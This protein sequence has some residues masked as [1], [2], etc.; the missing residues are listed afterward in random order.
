MIALIDEEQMSGEQESV[1]SSFHLPVLLHQTVSLLQPGPGKLFLDGT[2][3]GGGHALALL[4]AGASVIGCDQD[5]EALTEAGGDLAK[6]EEVLRKKGLSAAA[7]KAGRV[8]S[9]GAVASYIHMGGKIGV[10]VEVNCETDFVARTPEFKTLARDVALQIAA[11]APQYVSRADVPADI[12]DA[13]R[14]AYVAQAKADGKPEAVAARIAEGKLEKFFATISL[15]DQPFIRDDGSEARTV[16]DVVK[17][18]IAKT[19]EN[20]QVRRFARFRLGEE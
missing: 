3:G 17:E 5:P 7:K 4:E 1:G 8:A 15:M 19:G 6:A 16:G 11:S 18:V 12:V 2:I 10:L 20:I 13:E 9:E 14:A